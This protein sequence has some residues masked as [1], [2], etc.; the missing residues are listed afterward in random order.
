MYYSRLTVSANS[1]AVVFSALYRAAPALG[2][3]ITSRECRNGLV[4]DQNGLGV[5]SAIVI[6][7]VCNNV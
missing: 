5:V 3:A 4:V 6:E 7:F 2:F 1:S